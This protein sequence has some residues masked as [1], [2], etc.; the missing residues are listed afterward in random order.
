[1]KLTDKKFTKKSGILDIQP[2]DYSDL[3][4]A[5]N[6]N[7]AFEQLFDK[8][9]QVGGP[10]MLR[11]PMTDDPQGLM[12]QDDI[13]EANKTDVVDISDVWPEH[14]IITQAEDL[15]SQGMDEGKVFR[16][17]VEMGVLGTPSPMAQDL[18]YL[19]NIL[20]TAQVEG[21]PGGPNLSPNIPQKQKDDTVRS[22]L[23]YLKTLQD[24][25]VELSAM[26]S[27]A[28]HPRPFSPNEYGKADKSHLRREINI[29]RAKISKAGSI[30]K[31]LLKAYGP[32]V[33]ESE[34][35]QWLVQ[36]ISKGSSPVKEKEGAG[37]GPAGTSTSPIDGQR[38]TLSSPEIDG[39]G[40]IAQQMPGAGP[41]GPGAAPQP[42]AQTMGGQPP[43]EVG[44]SE[45]MVGDE[46]EDE[47]IDDMRSLEEVMNDLSEDVDV[48][49]QKIT[50]GET[51]LDGEELVPDLSDSGPQ[52]S[53]P[54]KIAVDKPAKDYWKSYFNDY[55]EQMTKDRSAEVIDLIDRV[56]SEYKVVLSSGQFNRVAD[57]VS[58]RPQ[59]KVEDNRLSA[60][61]D[62]VVANFLF[63]TGMINGTIPDECSSDIQRLAL[64]NSSVGERIMKFVADK[65]KQPKVVG[66]SDDAVKL[67][68]M[69]D[70]A[71]DSAPAFRQAHL[72]MEVVGKMRSG[73]YTKLLIE[74]DP[75]HAAAERGDASI[76]H[77]I[78]SFVKGL[79]SRKEFHDLGFLGQI[80]LEDFDP[81]AGMACAYFRTQKSDAP[82]VVT[83]EEV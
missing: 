4:A 74:W 31:K 55:G 6:P 47:L 27:D 46:S 25:H 72:P 56:S 12:S 59:L 38:D 1:M 34:E 18:D 17:L 75:D 57:F 63:K 78:I 21:P 43:N 7:V 67:D 82:L 79:E 5:L 69:K 14:E 48:L 26:L 24:K 53:G 58:T 36:Q 51:M 44:P 68:K 42:G 28:E 37:D 70:N 80:Q 60:L 83:E 33:M 13:P 39:T 81:E 8:I 2:V 11:E 3:R 61:M 20:K 73:V 35:V 52:P 19:T 32:E 54:S 10:D 71:K 50:N 40:K 23:N 16:Q 49:K 30:W 64:N 22:F 45:L 9:A 41:A 15:R 77:A 66:Q 76:K 65:M 29:L 62:K